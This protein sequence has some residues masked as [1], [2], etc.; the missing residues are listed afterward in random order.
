MNQPKEKKEKDDTT[1]LVSDIFIPGEFPPDQSNDILS[2]VAELVDSQRDDDVFVDGETPDET[3]QIEGEIT[4]KEIKRDTKLIKYLC[5]SHTFIHAKVGFYQTILNYIYPGFDESNKSQILY[6]HNKQSLRSAVQK[7]NN[8]LFSERNP[9]ILLPMEKNDEM[10]NAF[11]SDALDS[12]QIIW[13]IAHPKTIRRHL[14]TPFHNF[15]LASSSVDE[16]SY[17]RE[18][19]NISEADKRHLTSETRKG[20]LFATDCYPS[21]ESLLHSNTLRMGR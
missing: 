19:I 20:A 16:I 10:V 12:D 5:N 8:I 14:L 11:V 7:T 18:I 2:T 13:L 1:S 17:V 6:I 9:L 4:L 3:Y 21:R 15:F